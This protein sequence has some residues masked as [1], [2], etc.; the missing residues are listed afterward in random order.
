MLLS[1]NAV[2]SA[3]FLVLNFTSV[4]VLY[5]LLQAP[6][7]AMIQITVYAGAIMVLFLF[8]IMLLGAG[9]G[10]EERDAIVWQR[11]LAIVL[12]ILLLA[13]TAY[14]F[15]ARGG[16]SAAAPAATTTELGSP[17]AIAEALFTTYLL[18]FEMT[19]VLLLVALLGAVVLT[20][21]S[22]TRDKGSFSE[23]RKTLDTGPVTT[24]IPEAVRRETVGSR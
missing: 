10:Q 21:K 22:R 24:T 3:L 11:P 14:V 8:V 7:L 6:F 16:P 2:H 4:A 1:R 20:L 5:L 18:P 23:A 19:S 17:V 15:F 13:E 9:Q 12:G